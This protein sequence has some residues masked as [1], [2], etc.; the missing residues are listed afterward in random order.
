MA[1]VVCG[2]NGVALIDLFS[3][4]TTQE[5]YGG[6]A[7]ATACCWN[8]AYVENIKKVFVI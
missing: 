5:I 3:G 8:P 1:A 4:N 6:N 7:P 2:H